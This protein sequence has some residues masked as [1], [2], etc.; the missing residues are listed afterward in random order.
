[1]NVAPVASPPATARAADASAGTSPDFSDLL[2]AVALAADVPKPMAEPAAPADAL[3][4][5]AKPA[6]VPA[7][8]VA[9]AEPAP[10]AV[11]QAAVDLLPAAPPAPVAKAPD[12]VPVPPPPATDEPVVQNPTPAKPVSPQANDQV[13][14]VPAADDAAIAIALPAP[15]KD[16]AVAVAADAPAPAKGEGRKKDAAAKSD[17]PKAKSAQVDL[18][19][20][21]PDQQPVVQAPAT[22]I[23]APVAGHLAA[24]HGDAE[25]EAE[26]KGGVALAGAAPAAAPREGA[27]AAPLPSAHDNLPPLLASQTPAAAISRPAASALPYTMPPQSPAILAQ[28]GR[29]GR[30]M[31]VE[32]ARQVSA[33]RDEVMIRL[34]PAEMGRVDVRL[35]FDD[36]GS[37]HAAVTADSPAA[38]DMLRRDAG[39]LGRAL[40]DAGIR[41]DASSFRFDS[42]SP[43]S[44]QFAQQQHQ[45]GQQGGDQRGGGRRQQGGDDNDFGGTTPQAYRQL[46]TSGRID[47]MA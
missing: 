24:R 40:S 29:I 39:D 43:D 4:P 35:S 25:P 19:A 30:D 23:A 20:V 46:R 3:P 27:E 28:P 8:I 42:R 1:M 12:S 22:P 44:G 18:P 9:Q 21:L 5:P 10:V 33:G 38:L 41:A 36:K 32:I 45:G 16:D 11:E 14:T 17:A 26:G 37:L 7:P 31:G 13:K 15:A 6:P 2:G 47:L 34:D